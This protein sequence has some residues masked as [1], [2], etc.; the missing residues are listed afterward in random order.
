MTHQVA[1]AWPAEAPAT[2]VPVPVATVTVVSRSPG[3]LVFGPDST[4]VSLSSK[5]SE[6]MSPTLVCAKL[7]TCGL[8]WRTAVAPL[9]K[10]SDTVRLAGSTA[11]M[12]A[13]AE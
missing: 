11:V 12:R 9:V 4:K 10:A 8:T 7:A 5:A 13:S 2:L 1:T 6:T 3:V